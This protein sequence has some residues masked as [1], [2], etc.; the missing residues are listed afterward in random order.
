MANP[1]LT[2]SSLSENKRLV[3]NYLTALSGEPKTPE[4]IARYVSDKELS[5]HIQQIEAAFPSYELVAEDMI[6]E[7]DLVVVRGSFRGVHQGL[8]FGIQ[9]SSKSV[10]AG[11]VIIY[12]LA[13]GRIAEHW[14]QFDLFGL[15]E[16]LKATP[17]AAS[18]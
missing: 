17:A 9:P 16:Q 8:F 15:L 6:A 3:T 5:D 11:L 14:L 7:R 2:N 18:S 1:S 4:L 12:R 10:T 13:N